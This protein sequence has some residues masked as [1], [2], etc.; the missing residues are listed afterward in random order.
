MMDEHEQLLNDW[1][2]LDH[3][4]GQRFIRDGIIDPS[5]WNLAN[6]KS[7]FFC[8]RLIGPMQPLKDMIYAERFEK[9]GKDQG[10]TR[11]GRWR[12]GPTWRIMGRELMFRLFRTCQQKRTEKDLYLPVP[13]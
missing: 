7:S 3:H 5:R 4:R 1:E 6:R 9:R 13:W 11:G 2:Q 8:E 12:I 10:E